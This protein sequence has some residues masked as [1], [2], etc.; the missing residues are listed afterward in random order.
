MQSKIYTSIPT[1]QSDKKKESTWV[2][3]KDNSNPR[4]KPLNFQASFVG[5]MPMYATAEVVA[6]YL[7]NHSA[8]FSDCAK[9][10]K[11]EPLEENAYMIGLGNFGSL[12]YELEAQIAVKL[13]PPQGRV[14]LMET[15]PIPN[16]KP[17][18]YHVNYQAT[19]ELKEVT[20]EQEAQIQKIFAKHGCTQFPPRMTEV[21]WNLD[22]ELVVTF[23]QFIYKFPLAVIK[24]AGDKVLSKVV[25][26]V[27]H[28]LTH[29]VQKNFHQSLHLP[30]PP[31]NSNT[32]IQLS[33][34][35]KN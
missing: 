26:Q 4:I 25:N 5:A 20:V 12:G 17:T 3:S 23:P 16:C 33:T 30:V 14:Y 24:K 7:N 10:M 31:K 22:L 6:R 15:I 11:T 8:W 21:T 28:R 35:Q 2:D 27:S 18:S 32:F 19:M 29:K 9:P 13:H 1:H 34:K